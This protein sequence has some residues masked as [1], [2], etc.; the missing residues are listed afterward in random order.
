MEDEA[1]IREKLEQTQAALNDK[2]G[3]LEQ[4]VAG[5]V[6]GAASAVSETVETVKDSIQETV[7]TVKD[8]VQGTVSSVKETVE[9]SVA[10]VKNW[11]DVPGHTREHP[12]T[13][14]A[15]SVAMGFLLE[16][17][18]TLSPAGSAAGEP[19]TPR[20]LRKPHHHEGNGG[21]H[22]HPSVRE[23]PHRLTDDTLAPEMAKLKGLV[24]GAVLGT[25]REIVLQAVP[26]T[27]GD[28]LREIIDSATQKVGG[29]VLPGSETASWFNS[30]RE[31]RSEHP[32]NTAEQSGRLMREK[33]WSQ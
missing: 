31:E 29:T 20:R 32:E 25:V 10:T 16:R 21:L 2:L 3:A 30:E 5:T 26:Q 23:K 33:R 7:A 9:E 12:W 15:G 11:F 22:P 14:L 1:M 13:M 27:L 18:L 24:L 19:E 8:T 17:M 28:H 4:T 6:E